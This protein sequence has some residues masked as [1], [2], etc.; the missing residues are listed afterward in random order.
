VVVVEREPAVAEEATTTVAKV[1]LE[2]FL[3]LQALQPITQAEDLEDT[4]AHPQLVEAEGEELP[5][6]QILVAAA[7]MAKLV[8]QE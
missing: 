6:R 7:V 2:E 1:V 3:T 8:P 4:E 5:Q